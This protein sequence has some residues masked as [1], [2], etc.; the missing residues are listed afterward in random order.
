MEIECRETK[1]FREEDLQRLFRSVNWES[2]EYPDR[3]VRG[4]RNSSHVITAWDGEKLV[5]L[6]R[7]LDDGA[8]AAFL[9][10]LLVDPEYQGYH[11]GSELMK[12][13]MA[14]Y[15]DLLYVKVIPSDPDTI[16]FYERF[17][18]RQYEN[19]SAMVKKNFH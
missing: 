3:L 2:A 12:R 4:M 1:E 14:Y 7:G 18:F 11:I 17:G 5:G 9:H 13:I 15:E 16:R 6:V 8:T 19:Y 10:Y